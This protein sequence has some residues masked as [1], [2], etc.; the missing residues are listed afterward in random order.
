MGK[1]KVEDILDGK[2]AYQKR[3]K[4]TKSAPVTITTEEIRSAR[5]L[6]RLLAF[7]QD[8]GRSKHGMQRSSLKTKIEINIL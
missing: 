6:G 8:A 3:Q 5:Q 2:E 1:R 4:I 7:D